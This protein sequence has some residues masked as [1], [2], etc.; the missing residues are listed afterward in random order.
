MPIHDYQCMNCEETY[1]L[2]VSLDE[3]DM[4]QE[5]ISCGAKDVKRLV[6]TPHFKLKGTGWYKTDY[7]GK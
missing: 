1:E 4:P 2:M 6:G 5:C 7:K 3:V